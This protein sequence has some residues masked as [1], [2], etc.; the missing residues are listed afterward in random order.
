[1]KRIGGSLWNLEWEG[2]CPIAMLDFS[3][4]TEGYIYS[5]ENEPKL[6]PCWT[7]SQRRVWTHATMHTYEVRLWAQKGIACLAVFL[8]IKSISNEMEKKSAKFKN[9]TLVSESSSTWT[10]YFCSSLL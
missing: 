7:I 10:H 3:L 2:L 8:G 6:V 5:W 9:T 1:M 4:S